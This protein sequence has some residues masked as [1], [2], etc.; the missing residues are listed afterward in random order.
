[1]SLSSEGFSVVRSLSSGL[2]FWGSVTKLFKS[3]LLSGRV[4]AFEVDAEQ[5]QPTQT[6]KFHASALEVKIAK[7]GRP[8]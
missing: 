8:M 2:G 5:R 7:I 6:L 1:M 3:A 4:N